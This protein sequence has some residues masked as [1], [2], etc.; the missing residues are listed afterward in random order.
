[1]GGGVGLGIQRLRV[2]DLRTGDQ[3]IYNEDGSIVVV[4]NGEIY[5]YRELR[6][7]LQ[8]SGHKFATSGDTEVIVHLYEEQGPACV[9]SLDG[10]FAFALWDARR[11]RLLLTRDRVGKKPLFYALRNGSLTFASE[12]AALVVAEVID[13]DV[14]PQALD[15]FLAYGY[16]QA[17]LSIFRGVSKLPPASTLVY[18]QGKIEIE[19]YW[20]LD[21]S[22]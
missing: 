14:D 6:S 9:R 3:P 7:Q 18:R 13:R 10:M 2:I 21:Y 20:R 12:L 8:A 5:N 1:M 19:R 15:C 16:I 4:F 11:S 17:P 22:R